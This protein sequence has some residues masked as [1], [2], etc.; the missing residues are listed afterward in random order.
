MRLTAAHIDLIRR[1]ATE[2]FGERVRVT[3]FGSR[4]DDHAKGG[5]GDLLFDVPVPVEDPALKM[6][7]LSSRLS[8]AM[9]GRRV[10]VLIGAPNVSEQPIH[11]IARQTGVAL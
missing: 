8:R 6:A 9:D 2:F 7:R 10:D 1:T 4:V 11:K 3:L 5:D